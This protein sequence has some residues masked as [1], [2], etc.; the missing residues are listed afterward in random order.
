MK[1]EALAGPENHQELGKPETK[2]GASF[3]RAALLFFLLKWQV[4][5]N[6]NMEMGA[7]WNRA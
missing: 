6:V 4:C 1:N 3:L 7:L 2:E 5:P